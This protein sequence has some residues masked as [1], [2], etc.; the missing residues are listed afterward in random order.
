M[1][2]PTKNII[3]TNYAWN[4]YVGFCRVVAEVAG[5]PLEMKVVSAEEKNSAEHK[6]INLTGKYP[7]LVTAQG[8]LNE[9]LAIAKFLA[10]GNDL[11]GGDA[12]TKAKID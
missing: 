1:V 8:C 4:P 7:C 11:A 9:S 5:V 2:E 10:H 3:Y 6:A 12:W